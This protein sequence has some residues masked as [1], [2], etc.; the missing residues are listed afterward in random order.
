[1][2]ADG[3]AECEDGVGVADGN[4]GE[5]V[6][7]QGSFYVNIVFISEIFNIFIGKILKYA[8]YLLS[9]YKKIKIVR[10]NVE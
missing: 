10:E 2:V 1:M 8:F 5:F 4:E 9:N 6:T 7:F 3:V